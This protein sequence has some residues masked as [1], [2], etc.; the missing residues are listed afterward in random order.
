MIF[1]LFCVFWF[2]KKGNANDWC[3][4]ILALFQCPIILNS[5][6]RSN[7]YSFEITCLQQY[8]MEIPQEDIT[9]SCSWSGK[10]QPFQPKCIPGLSVTF[11]IKKFVNDQFIINTHCVER[12]LCCTEWIVPQLSIRMN[13]NGTCLIL[14]QWLIGLW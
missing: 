12:N 9:F 1:D 10:W 14:I 5:V 11:I 6:M 2:A 3:R 7:G 4:F 8:E 13:Y